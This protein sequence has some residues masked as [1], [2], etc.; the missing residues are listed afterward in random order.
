M[1]SSKLLPIFAF[2]FLFSLLFFQSAFA[3]DQFELD[4]FS[5]VNTI[6]TALETGTQ[7]KVNI[8]D[9]TEIDFLINE[10]YLL[11]ATGDIAGE[12]VGNELGVR[13]L[14]GTT[15]F[16]GGAMM[17]EPNQNV[18]ESEDLCAPPDQGDGWHTYFW[19]TVWEPTTAGEATEDIVVEL[20]SADD[21][22]LFSDNFSIMA[23]HLNSTLIFE[24][25][26]WF[27]AE[28]T[29]NTTL[30]TTF[31]G[32]GN[33]TL[34]FTPSVNN[35]K[36]LILGTSQMDTGVATVNYQTRMF[37]NGT[38]CT[39]C[40]KPIISVEGEDPASEILVQSFARA[41]NLT[42]TA[43]TIQTQTAIDGAGGG[44][45][46]RLYSSIFAL[47]LDKFDARVSNY[48]DPEADLT[49]VNYATNVINATII[50][51]QTEDIVI[52]ADIGT[53]DNDGTGSSQFRVQVNNII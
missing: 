22:R 34:N 13:L 27:F 49:D 45:Q 32:S 47:N 43:Q 5:E 31:G 10:K 11:I 28:N 46:E 2:V 25:L 1:K 16:E 30:T 42:N 37:V 12:D 33:A 23:I 53:K 44:T 38:E 21:T 48:I 50:T 9:S 18:E 39:F 4:H 17:L 7:I 36:W 52:I 20:D 15:E 41:I 19:W 24:N 29:T 26:D 51:P 6:C 3:T 40:D 8:T 35:T 14:H